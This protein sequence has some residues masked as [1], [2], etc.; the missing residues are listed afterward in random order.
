MKSMNHQI[1]QAIATVGLITI[2]GAV[3]SSIPALAL[4]SRFEEAWRNNLN[5]SNERFD[6]RSE[7]MHQ[8]DLN[9]LNERFEKAREQ[10]LNS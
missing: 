4:N 5:S 8:N 6:N 1:L 3:L 10:I 7:N 2:V 9:A